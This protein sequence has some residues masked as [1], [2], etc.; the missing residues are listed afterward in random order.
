MR[1]EVAAPANGAFQGILGVSSVISPDGQTLAMAVTTESG[2]RLFVR[3]L[4][5]TAARP[6][7]GTEGAL[8]PFWSPDSRSLGFFAGGKM[9]RV[10]LSGGAPQTICDA[11][12]RPWQLATWAPDNT[13]LFTGYQDSGALFRVPAAGGQPV[14]ALTAPSLQTYWW[15]SFLPDGRHFLYFELNVGKPSEVRVGSLDS[16]ETK[17]VLPLFSR[18]LYRRD[19]APAVRP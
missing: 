18:A 2:P 16:P 19:G 8:N 9:K 12:A 15:P 17:S 7:E 10:A 4:A 1:F 14:A 6:L 11:P 3:P 5:S 13:I